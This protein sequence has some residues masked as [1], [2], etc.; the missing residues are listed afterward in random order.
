[1][2]GLRISLVILAAALFITGVTGI[3]Y[4]YH[5]GGVA[6]CEG[7]H[8]MHNS[9][10]NKSVVPGVAQ[11]VGAKYLLKG[12]DQS[13]T[14]L[15]CHGTTAAK[16]GSSYYVMSTDASAS[17]TPGGMTPGG[18]FGWIKMGDI[19]YTKS[20]GG[21]GTN[22]GKRRGHNIVATDFGMT[23]STV[24][25]TAPGGVYPSNQFYCSSCHDPHS[26]A[27]IDSTGSLV[28]RTSGSN[29][30]AIAQ[31]GSYPV[32]AMPAAGDAYGVYR[33]LGGNGYLPKSVSSIA[34]IQFTANPPVAVAPATYNQLETT[35]EVRVA[36]G[37]GMS[38]WCSNCHG[39]IHMDAYTTGTAGLQHPAGNGAKFTSAIAANYNAY[40][41]S[42]NLTN[43]NNNASYT[44][45]VPFERGTG[46]SGLVSLGALADNT[47]TV[48]IAGPDTTSNVMCLSCHRAHSSAWKQMVRYQGATEGTF[49]TVDGDYVGTDGTGEQAYGEYNL[50]YTKAQTKQAYYGRNAT[51][52]ATFQRTL[53]N[54]CH[55]KD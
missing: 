7:C 5:D 47:N 21:T 28:T 52:F 55:A 16:A 45:L 33:F 9:V 17:V 19:A 37:S 6:R 38:E 1:M 30:G 35:N 25:T 41:Y 20:Y 14:C 53:C 49:I 18:D 46:A 31:S 39:Q 4:A 26:A 23:A 8:T 34:N 54:K 27:R 40:V 10:D 44:S 50:G 22:V 15:Q 43:T 29:V 12:N 48:T 13:S 11:F 24:F 2:K 51:T 32:T 36:Y 3:G 42:G